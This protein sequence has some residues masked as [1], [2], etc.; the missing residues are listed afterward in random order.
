MCIGTDRNRLFAEF[1]ARLV[2]QRTDS[3]YTHLM[4]YVYIVRCTVRERGR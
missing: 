1:V 4:L 3:M 2:Q